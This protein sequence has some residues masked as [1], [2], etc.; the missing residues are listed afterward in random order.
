M[1]TREDYLMI[2]E[3]RR[4]GV[5]LKDIAAEL[6]VHPRTVPRALQRGSE[7]PRRPKRRP[8]KLDPYKAR[9]DEML[10]DGV[11][12]AVREF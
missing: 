1:L 9:I 11:W 12:N 10:G 7:L 2:S 6:G 5:F 3:R 8:S 4:Q